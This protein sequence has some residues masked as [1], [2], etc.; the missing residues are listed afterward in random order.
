MTFP[1]SPD[2]IEAAFLTACR[3]ELAALK[4]GNV[5]GHAAGHDMQVAHFERAAEAAAPHIASQGARVGERI[6]AAVEASVAAAGCN[7]NLGILLLCAPLAYAAGEVVQGA[8]LPERLATVLASLDEK[9]AADTFAAIAAASPGG[10]G[11]AAEGDVRAPAQMT[12]QAAMRLAAGRDRIALAYV[13][14]FAD[15]FHFAAPAY[16]RAVATAATPEWA[17]T[18]LHMQLLAAFPDTHV[19]RKFGA[20]TA[21]TVRSEAAALVALAGPVGTDAAH[22]D[23]LAFDASLKAR[24]LN[25]GTTADFVV[26]TLFSHGLLAA[27]CG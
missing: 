1:L 23:L 14:G 3:L 21:E 11:E 25:P 6:R 24:G 18:T 5:H 15:V 9:D 19:S 27:G 2:A 13:T 4:P 10:L 7:T 16:R 17:V 12:L 8:T 22:R 20:Q 26:A